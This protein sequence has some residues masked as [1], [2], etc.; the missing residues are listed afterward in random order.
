MKETLIVTHNGRF[1]V[2]EIFAIAIL[3]KFILKKRVKSL[4]IIRTR[5]ESEIQKFQK[6]K[7][8]YVI[9]VG[10]KFD[11]SMKNFDH[12][13]SDPNLVW[14]EQ[15]VY[16]DK[17]FEKILLSA[18]GLIWQEFIKV[19]PTEYSY[20][21]IKR[22]SESVQKVDI[23]DNGLFPWLITPIFSGYNTYSESDV[24]S[25]DVKFR[26]ALS[27]VEKYLDNVV[28]NVSESKEVVVKTLE[29]NLTKYL[30]DKKIECALAE[31]MK[32]IIFDK[33][34]EMIVEY[35][36]M[37]DFSEK[38]KLN[39]SIF[40]FFENVE[41]KA[42]M[43]I[44]GK[45]VVKEA[46]EQS[47]KDGHEEIVFFDE[48]SYDARSSLRELSDKALLIATFY[49]EEQEWTIMSVNKEKNDPYL[50]RILMPEE[51]A[52]KRKEEL[53]KASGFKGMF[54]CHKLRFLTIFRGEKEECL[55]VCK[56]I[57]S[58]SKK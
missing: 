30:S 34:F 44:K 31:E 39:E 9:D 7:N 40:H 52:G 33:Y 51:W 38:N 41:Y 46:L 3:A 20:D 57:I 37:F 26:Q 12:H 55:K 14:K 25:G 50:G 11:C 23:C 54:Y 45:K 42:K 5:N 6:D 19:K 8:V 53:E 48:K 16:K 17:M 28:K 18:C 32:G 58:F 22:L 2:D 47:I 21:E 13:Q 15:I 10:E 49:P 29:E 1:H 43:A 35:L 56:E 4:K 24:K 27:E 36:S